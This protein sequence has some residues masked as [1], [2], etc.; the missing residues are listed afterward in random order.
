MRT[1]LLS[2]KG[3]IIIPKALRDARHWHAGTRLQVQETSDGLLLKAVVSD[4]K[5]PLA[6]GLAAIRK[7]IAYKGAAVSVDDMH[8]A[9]LSEAARRNKG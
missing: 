3:Q 6:E 8:A 7:R 1:T 5:L 4:V 2:S 9:V